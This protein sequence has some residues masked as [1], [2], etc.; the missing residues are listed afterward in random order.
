[1]VAPV[2]LVQDLTAGPYQAGVTPAA[3]TAIITALSS[4]WAAA[5]VLNDKPG[6]LTPVLDRQ[7]NGRSFSF[8]WVELQNV[9]LLAADL[10]AL[11]LRLVPR[12]T[13]VALGVPLGAT[14]L[15]GIQEN[16]GSQK[17]PVE[18]FNYSAE[19]AGTD[20]WRGTL[21]DNQNTPGIRR[22]FDNIQP[23]ITI[24]PEDALV[25]TTAIASTLTGTLD[26]SVRGFYQEQPE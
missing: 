11:R 15:V 21:G 23:N 20:I 16:D 24:G 25:F 5:I 7:F 12:A 22:T 13:V 26:I 4:S 14:S 18:I 9:G 6:S 3:G 2:V 19:L 8:T 17:V 10:S 1:M